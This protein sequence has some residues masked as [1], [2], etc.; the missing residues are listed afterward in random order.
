ML[1]I[2]ICDDDIHMRTYLAGLCAGI[3]PKASVETYESGAGLLNSES[4]S[5]I[6]LM[7]VNMEEMDGLETI[8]Q[9]PGRS[10]SK[11]S[12]P[13][14][15]F[16]T[17][18][19]EYVFDALDLFAFH[20][21]L[22]PLD[23]DK[24]EEIL[25]LAAVE[26]GGEEKEKSLLFHTKSTH[27][28]IK[29]SQILYV[30]SSLRKAVIHTDLEIFEIYSTMGELETLLGSRFFRCHRGYLV[31]LEKISGYDR[32]SIRL[33]DGSSL[34]LSKPKYREFVNTYL[35]FLK[36]EEAMADLG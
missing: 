6:I 10:C 29:P 28:R 32:Q 35:H 25:K 13:V 33:T 20:Y 11:G 8:K 19:D 23:E 31:N 3:L 36:K 34:I 22:K 18:Y 24:F 5:D 14:V 17:A 30:E 9:L 12:R 21:L 15:I 26:C 1:K 2:G 16:I 7:D 27:L 4:K